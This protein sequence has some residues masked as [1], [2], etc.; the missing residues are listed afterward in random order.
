M[1]TKKE[2]NDALTKLML[3]PDNAARRAQRE[4]LEG[5]R[6]ESWV[7]DKYVRNVPAEEKDENVF[8]AARDAA[9]FVAGKLELDSVLEVNPLDDEGEEPESVTVSATFLLSLLERVEQLEKSV[10]L[11]L[12][13]NESKG[14]VP[15]SRNSYDSFLTT[16]EAAFYIGCTPATL[17]S[18]RK[19]GLISAQQKGGTWIFNSLELSRNATVLL[20]QKKNHK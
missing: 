20:Y 7:F 5:G 16:D 9:Q 13:G 14:I 10:E 6:S 2:I 12:K 4:V 1:R 8:Y 18:W 15:E 19:K 17:L 3:M 11:L